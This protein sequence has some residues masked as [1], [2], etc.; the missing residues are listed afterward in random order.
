MRRL[1]FHVANVSQA[2]FSP[3]GRWIVTAGPT[4]AGIWQVRTGR[5]LY[6]LNG[7]RGNLTAAAWAPDSQRIVVGD[8]GGGVETFRCTVCVGI[9]ALRAQADALLNGLG[10]P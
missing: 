4:T 6:F 5:L 1:S 10:P 3:D 8:S 9:P 7:A 2:A